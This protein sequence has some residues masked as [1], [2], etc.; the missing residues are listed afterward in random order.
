MFD[1]FLCNEYSLKQAHVNNVTRLVR[2][3][4]LE[5]VLVKCRYHCMGV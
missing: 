1:C 5:G 4:S 2:T 3:N